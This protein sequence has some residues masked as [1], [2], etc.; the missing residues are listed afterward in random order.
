LEV[1]GEE[2]IVSEN[3]LLMNVIVVGGRSDAFTS[4]SIS[5]R[6]ISSGDFRRSIGTWVTRE[7]MVAGM[8]RG[9]RDKA[10]ILVHRWGD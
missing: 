9:L 7:A 6:A 5:F 3:T 8:L 2:N 1:G 4:P 10:W